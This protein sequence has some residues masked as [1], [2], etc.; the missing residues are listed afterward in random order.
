[1]NTHSHIISWRI[2]VSGLFSKDWIW[3]DQGIGGSYH[4]HY[5]DST[6]S[7]SAQSTLYLVNSSFSRDGKNNT[8]C[9]NL[10]SRAS[11]T[12]PKAIST[13]FNRPDNFLL[14][15]SQGYATC[16][17]I[18][19]TAVK[20]SFAPHKIIRHHQWQ[21]KRVLYHWICWWVLTPTLFHL[22]NV[23]EESL[24]SID[25]R[26]SDWMSVCNSRWM[27]TANLSSGLRR[28]LYQPWSI[29]PLELQSYWLVTGVS[30]LSWSM[31]QGETICVCLAFQHIQ[32]LQPLDV[33][34]F[35]PVTAT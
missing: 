9:A 13:W 12:T 16:N 20:W 27:E 30:I 5:T 10:S 22:Y 4:P 29:S 8:M 3:N 6:K 24:E 33:G 23:E 25:A 14:S 28:Y 18:Y 32:L 7:I 19:G 2:G 35:G 31:L 17:T 1:M 11:A 21:K 15:R 26:K 34:I